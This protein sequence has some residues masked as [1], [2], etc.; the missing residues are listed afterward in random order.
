MNTDQQNIEDQI[1]TIE[2]AIKRLE[3]V[4]N[5]TSETTSGDGHFDVELTESINVARA[6]LI[7]L[8]SLMA[9]RSKSAAWNTQVF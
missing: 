5:F 4:D 8:K 3:Q 7:R 6:A 1:A 2:F 9:E